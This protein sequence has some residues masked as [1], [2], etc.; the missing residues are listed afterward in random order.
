MNPN[1]NMSIMC[2]G[3]GYRFKSNETNNSNSLMEVIFRNVSEFCG[4]DPGHVQNKMR[5]QIIFNKWKCS[6]FFLP[7]NF[8]KTLSAKF[9]NIYMRN[10]AEFRYELFRN[11]F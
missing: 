11:K 1:L 9:R 10:F 5:Q 4:L 2:T 3:S 8:S 6:T 7:I